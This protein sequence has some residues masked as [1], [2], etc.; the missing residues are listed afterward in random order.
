MPDTGDPLLQLVVTLMKRQ[1]K[2]ITQ[3]QVDLV[4]SDNE[5]IFSDGQDMETAIKYHTINSQ[6]HFLFD[7]KYYPTFE[8]DGQFVTLYLKGTS[9]GNTL[10]D[11]SGFNNTADIL[12]DPTLIR[13]HIRSRHPYLRS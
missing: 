9:L 11:R 4:D 5:D 2:F 6:Q 3:Q 7:K 1:A 13:K 12:G 8:P 10:K